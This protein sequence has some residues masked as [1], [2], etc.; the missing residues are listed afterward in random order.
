MCARS[1]AYTFNTNILHRQVSVFR[2]ST[3]FLLF[4]V[5]F[6][7]R[8]SLS[9]SERE[10]ERSENIRRSTRRIGRTSSPPGGFLE[11][12]K[13]ETTAPRTTT[14]VYRNFRVVALSQSC[15]WETTIE[16][17]VSPLFPSRSHQHRTQFDF[18]FDST[19]FFSLFFFL[20]SSF[21][22]SLSFFF[23]FICRSSCFFLFFF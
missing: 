12:S 21:L 2:V 17:A 3:V 11:G 6:H 9:K 16:E 7:A 1:P 22:F 13:E 4:P 20:F 19:F 15:C 14:R 10:R 8:L 5:R 18:F 23:N